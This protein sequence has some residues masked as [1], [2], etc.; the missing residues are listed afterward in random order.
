MNTETNFKQGAHGDEAVFWLW[1]QWA[2]VLRIRN[3][4][5]PMVG[6]TWYSLIDQVDWDTALREPNG[7]VN[8]LGLFDLDRKIRP[9]GEAYRKLMLDWQYILPVSSV[10]LRVPVVRPSEQDLSGVR[11]APTPA[12]ERE[13]RREAMAN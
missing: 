8:P 5:V 4:G 3:D 11:C 9:V 2:N 6:F 7:N 12:T 1:K 10:C 13:R